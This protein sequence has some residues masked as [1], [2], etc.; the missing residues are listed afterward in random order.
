MVDDGVRNDDREAKSNESAGD[1]SR[2]TS[3]TSPR[4]WG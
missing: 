2:N 4:E 1:N 3:M